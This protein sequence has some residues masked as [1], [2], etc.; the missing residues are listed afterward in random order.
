MSRWSSSRAPSISAPGAALTLMWWSPAT[1]SSSPAASVDDLGEVDGQ[2]RRDAA[3][4]GPRE[5]QQVGDEPPHPA[6]RA[7]RRGRGLALLALELH[8]EQLEVRQHG[9]QRRAQLV[10]GVGHELA[11]AR[12][13]RLGL[14]AR[15]VRATASMLSSVSAS[16]ETSSLDAG[17]GIRS[18]GSRVRAIV[19][20][21]SVSRVIG[22]IARVAVAKPG[23]QGQRGAADH[24]EAEEDAHAVG[25]RLDVGQLARILHVDERRA[26]S[27]TGRDSTR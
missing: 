15:L 24:A 26:A 11:L 13:R 25:G 27:S 21:A 16:S 20:A 6:R 17:C 22:A 8:L 1:G 12:Q 10:R 3:G 19:R 23:Q 4:V 9:R 5:Q 14:A 7:Q 18:D 2:V